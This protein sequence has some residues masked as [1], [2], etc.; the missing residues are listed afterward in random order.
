MVRLPRRLDPGQAVAGIG[1]QQPGQVAGFH[2]RGSVGQGAAE[3]FPQSGAGVAGEGPWGLQPGLEVGG[4]SGQP[5]GFQL[6]GAALRV[7]AEQHE[8]AGVG[9]QH[10]SVAVPVAAHLVTIRSQPG[11]A[12][13]GFDLDHAAFGKLPLA[14]PAALH[15][16]GG[17]EAE[18]GMTCA[19]MSEL[20]DAE[21]L[22]LERAAD[23][24]QQ[25]GQRRVVGPFTRCPAR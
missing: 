11:V 17:I 15:L 25:I 1:S 7:L 6:G 16:L 9:D 23:G 2:Q 13:D 4:G 8:V 20:A 22:W 10:Q 19:L 14:L 18:V 24:I 21:N 12:A 5:E 3:I